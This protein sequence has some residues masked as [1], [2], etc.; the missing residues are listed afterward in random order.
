MCKIEEAVLYARFSPRKCAE[1]CQ[2]VDQQHDTL[3]DYCMANDIKILSLH[4][5]SGI[6]G[7]DIKRPG[8][9]SAVAQ[10]RRGSALMVTKRD[11]LARE[12]G[13]A[14]YIECEV[15]K[16]EAQVISLAGEGTGDDTPTGRLMRVIVDAFAEYEREMISMRTSAA[17]LRHMKDG[18]AMGGEMPYGYERDPE[19]EGQMRKCESE[20]EAIKE[21]ALLRK[22][23]YGYHGIAAAMNRE[24]RFKPRGNKW[25]GTTVM[26]ALN[27]LDDPQY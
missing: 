1:D 4:S 20:Q 15:K 19:H 22:C 8:L 7:S 13:L 3:S 24:G 27:R 18:R 14:C 5:D 23:G 9:W 21:M 16:K 26:R 11:R 17:M 6:S 10:L 25:H 12:V 2:S